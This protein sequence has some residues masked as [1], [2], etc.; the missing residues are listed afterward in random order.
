[1]DIHKALEV[2][3]LTDRQVELSQ[4]YAL[5]RVESA[6]NKWKFEMVLTA[7]LENIRKIKPNAGV[8]LATL[9]LMEI[10]PKEQVDEVKNYYKLWLQ[11]EAEY[12][13]L[14]K[15]LDA[16]HTKIMYAQSLMK[17]TKEGEN[18]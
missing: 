5:C 12:K 9:M 1:M 7:N 13:G 16:T 11:N 10:L 15:I 14:E 18:G 8:E 4:R 17:Y 6:K 3:R 2:E